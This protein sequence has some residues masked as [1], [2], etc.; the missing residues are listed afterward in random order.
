MT[1]VMIKVAV[2]VILKAEFN[3]K[4]DIKLKTIRKN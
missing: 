2:N 1:Y 4:K 3:T